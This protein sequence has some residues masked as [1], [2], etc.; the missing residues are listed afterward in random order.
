MLSL[1]HNGLP[2]TFR[3][4][5]KY[6]CLRGASP[7]YYYITMF[8]SFRAHISVIQLLCGLYPPLEL[9]L[10]KVIL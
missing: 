6:P 4:Q 3:S 9:E 5:H 7:S 10:H 2:A 8:T 1:A